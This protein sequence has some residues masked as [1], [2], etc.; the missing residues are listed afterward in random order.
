[1]NARVYRVL[2]DFIVALVLPVHAFARRKSIGGVL[3]LKAAIIPEDSASNV[4]KCIPA[5]LNARMKVYS[6]SFS[7]KSTEEESFLDECLAF[8]LRNGKKRK[9]E[10]FEK[11]S[12]LKK[13]FA[14]GTSRFRLDPIEFRGR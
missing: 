13:S 6:T 12:A 8:D 3:Q 5:I 9:S 14:I 10:R 7:I 4:F 1:M 2:V 11:E